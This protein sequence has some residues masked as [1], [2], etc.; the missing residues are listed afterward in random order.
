MDERRLALIAKFKEL[1][2]TDNGVGVSR[3]PGRVN[4]IGEHTDYN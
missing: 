2:G 3:A 4:I 1:F